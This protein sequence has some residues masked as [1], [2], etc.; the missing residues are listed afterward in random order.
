MSPPFDLAREFD[1]RSPWITR[2][3]IDGVYY[4]GSYD[5]AADHRLAKF[6]NFAS[7]ARTILELG[8]LEGGHS[9]AIAAR[10]SVERIVSVEG[11]EKSIDKARMVQRA[12]G[13]KKVEF[14]HANLDR[15]DIRELGRFDAVLCLGVLYHVAAPWRLIEQLAAVTDSIFVW[16]HFVFD[17]EAKRLTG[18]I[19]GRLQVERGFDDPLSGLVKR[20]AWLTLGS[21]MQCFARLSLGYIETCQIDMT[22]PD[23]PGVVFGARRTPYFGPPV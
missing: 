12:L 2:F 17:S 15:I 1:K 20:S 8:A 10:R 18:D 6:L 4:G 7:S 19:H 16:T 21:L 14:I 22:H 5:A 11:R 13:D 3:L 23:G 9:F